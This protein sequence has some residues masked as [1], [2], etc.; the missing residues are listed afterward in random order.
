MPD[1]C[2]RGET[3]PVPLLE[4]QHLT[5]CTA[6]GV[7]L[8]N[9]VSL[10]IHAGERWNIAGPNGVGKTVLMRSLALLDPLQGGQVL[11]CGSPI[12][13]VDIPAHRRR[14]MYLQQQATILPGSVAE[15]LALP[16]QFRQSQSAGTATEVE[17]RIEELLHRLGKPSSFLQLSA[18]TLSGGELQLVALMRGLLCDPKILLLDEATSALTDA[19]VLRVEH[20]LHDWLAES[21]ASHALVWVT[22]DNAQAARVADRTKELVPPMSISS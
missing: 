3:P 11:W 4:A 8:L 7:P 6:D 9:D 2:P 20:L 16:G 18:E 14:V 10:C 19:M 22:H 12:F 21:P 5:R 17:S 13:P 15:N 1:L